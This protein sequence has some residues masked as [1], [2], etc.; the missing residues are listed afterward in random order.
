MTKEKINLQHD[1]TR[2][3]FSP[4][5][6]G[7]EIPSKRKPLRLHPRVHTRSFSR[8]GIK[9]GVIP[10]GGKGT[11]LGWLGNYLPKSLVPLGQKPMLYYI[12]KNLEM[13]GIEQ[14]YLLVN[15]KSNLIKQYLKEENEFNNFKIRF[16]KSAPD[17]G[18]AE[19]IL[20]TER[21]IKKPFVT[22]LGDDFTK[23]PKLKQF[24]TIK[25]PKDAIVQEAVIIEK[26]Q[27]ILSQTC[28]IYINS[29]KQI[30]K[31]VEKPQKPKSNYRGC[32]IYLFKPEIFK[33]IKK[34]KP[35]KLTG[36][37]EITETIN[38][39]ANKNKAYAWPILGINVNINTQS[40]L[41]RATKHL[42][43]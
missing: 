4:P 24:T 20:K 30:T 6:V 16:L 36:K 32:G 33:Y 8:R 35:S 39:I 17:L 11:R 3:I 38:L 23:S 19:V 29:K 22:I 31:A 7:S 25:L 14:I 37:K 2:G 28:E 18:L 1:Y 26:N 9:I 21:F 34:T 15:Y 10:V 40:D 42:Y 12:I 27:T 13:M 5:L 43:N 41:E